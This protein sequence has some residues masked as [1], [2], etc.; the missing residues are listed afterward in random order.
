V[1][2]VVERDEFASAVA[3][4]ARYAPAKPLSGYGALSGLLVRATDGVLTVVG[5][6]GDTWAT[7]TVPARVHDEGVALL[8]ARLLADVAAKLPLADVELSLGGTEATL[9]CGTLSLTTPTVPAEDYPAVPGLPPALGEVD[10]APFAAAVARVAVA[11]ARE[12][13]QAYTKGVYLEGVEDGLRLSA[14]DRYRIART[15]VEWKPAAGRGAG[16][17]ALV[18]AVALSDLAKSAT[19]T[20]GIHLG[21]DAGSIGMTW[22]GRQVTTGLISTKLPAYDRAL[23]AHAGAVEA[24][25][26]VDRQALAEALGRVAVV[27]EGGK[28]VPRLYLDLSPGELTVRV[29]TDRGRTS[30]SVA[31]IYDGPGRAMQCNA[32]YLDAVVKSAGG[33]VVRVDLTPDARNSLLFYSEA[34]P[35]WVH[36]LVMLRDALREES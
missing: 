19:G 32:H 13:D 27:Y 29:G 24:S 26:T 5:A 8:P 31:V 35:Q 15:T 18:P 4:A 7:A 22:P 30:E 34:D 23:G 36:M 28:A 2:V 14:T 3:W 16:A 25:L 21:D 10:A 33:D 6:D 1:K 20:V 11:T 12:D 17:V 9:T